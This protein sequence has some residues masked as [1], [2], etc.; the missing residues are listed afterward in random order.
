[1]GRKS[2]T[3]VSGESAVPP[4]DPLIELA[5]LLRPP[6]E[7]LQRVHSLDLSMAQFATLILLRGTGAQSVSAVAEGIGLSR[8]ATSHLVERLVQRELLHREEDSKDRRQKQVSLTATSRRL[9][10]EIES[11]HR[12]SMRRMWSA[13]P[14]AERARAQELA[15]AL[16]TLLRGPISTTKAPE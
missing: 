8:A 9:F 16:L 14:A 7:G 15:R 1:M 2:G 13:V 4:S 11:A 10:E 3:K 6:L 5:F 12:Q